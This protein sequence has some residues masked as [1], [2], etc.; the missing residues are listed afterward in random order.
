M[1]NISLEYF[2]SNEVMKI[3]NVI[4]DCNILSEFQ[5]ISISRTLKV[6]R[7][8]DSMNMQKVKIEWG[9][10][11]SS[12]AFEILNSLKDRCQNI[13]NLKLTF[14]GMLVSTHTTESKEC[15]L[16]E[17]Q[18][19][20][21]CKIG[22]MLLYFLLNCECTFDFSAICP[23][24]RSQPLYLD[25]QMSFVAPYL[26]HGMSDF[27]QDSFLIHN[28]IIYTK[29]GP[30][31]QSRYSMP[32]NMFPDDILCHNQHL[33][34]FNVCSDIMMIHCFELH[35]QPVSELPP[36]LQC[37]SPTLSSLQ[38][39]VSTQKCVRKI[40]AH[41]KK[42]TP[43]IIEKFEKSEDVSEE[44]HDCWIYIAVDI[45]V[46]R[47]DHVTVQNQLKW[48]VDANKIKCPYVKHISQNI[49]APLEEEKNKIVYRAYFRG[50]EED[51]GD[52]IVH[53]PF[54]KPKHQN[55]SQ[56]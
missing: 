5:V 9:Y 6:I 29:Y 42:C 20:T 44:D 55:T 13:K 49:F 22:K 54:L 47:S 19:T 4:L 30:E 31:L 50:D 25:L 21:Q 1:E 23:H 3:W 18:D 39:I 33:S 7:N 14:Q 41:A 32:Y 2:T 46:M 27:P 15:L 16:T 37:L 12:D 56:S 26:S 38:Q 11:D 17:Q 34:T 35:L 8:S 24:D 51:L 43:I 28:K 36:L 53:I 52:V 45:R 48:I 10:V 40:I